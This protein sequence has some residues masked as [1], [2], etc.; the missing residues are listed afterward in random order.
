MSARRAV[1]IERIV[2]VVA[3]RILQQGQ[4]LLDEFL[5]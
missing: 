1:V 2:V 3:M 5:Q 4:Q